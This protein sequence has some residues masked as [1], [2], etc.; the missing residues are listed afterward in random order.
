MG[1]KD[2]ANDHGNPIRQSFVFLGTMNLFKRR[3]DSFDHELVRVCVTCN[4]SFCGRY[5]NQCGEKVTEPHERSILYFLSH[6]F[7]AFTFI[8]G[9][10]V[11]SLKT[12]IR[13]PGKMSY[14]LVQGKHTLYMKP[15][16]FFF[17]GNFIYFLFPIF[18]TFNTNLWAQMNMM[19]F[20]STW[21]S[22]W[23]HEVLAERQ[24]SLEDFTLL[25]AAQSTNMAKLLL[26]LLVPI[27][28]LFAMVIHFR[29]DRYYADHLLFSMEYCSFILFVDTLLLSFILRI[30]YFI[31]QLFGS[32]W[33]FL[34]H[35]NLLAVLVILS[36]G[37]FL[38][39]SERNF[40]QYRGLGAFL[41][42]LGMIAATTLVI[43][44]YR[45]ILFV[46][47]MLTV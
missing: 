3:P 12:L 7:N 35:D 42:L 15:V 19:R 20:Y 33:D 6:V 38:Y 17:V 41:R 45:L 11:T 31:G 10:F 9:K 4:N 37:Y 1:L 26:I 18:Q 24:M 32:D 25:Y 27:T 43:T 22:G 16:A 13:K 40:Y 39:F 21:A 36:F 28:S 44:I 8:D 46:A 29:R 5:C 34:F 2:R 47:T 14:D 30:I 23:V